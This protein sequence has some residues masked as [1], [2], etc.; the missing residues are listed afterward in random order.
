MVDREE[1]R[2]LALGQFHMPMS[3]AQRRDLRDG[4]L[5]LLAELE[6]AEVKNAHL[7]EC[8]QEIANQTY[9]RNLTAFQGNDELH[10]FAHVIYRVTIKARRYARLGE[11]VS[12]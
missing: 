11:K 3:P 5:S 2:Q 4:V 6:A 12:S 8:I 10:R 9:Y 1:L 7:W